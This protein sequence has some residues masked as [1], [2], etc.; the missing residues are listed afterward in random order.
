MLQ[1]TTID[2]VMLAV[3]CW[4]MVRGDWRRENM[5]YKLGVEAKD[6]ADARALVTIFK[7]EARDPN[8]RFMYDE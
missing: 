1:D 6:I 5:M 4:F 3:Y 8:V 7:H 2:K